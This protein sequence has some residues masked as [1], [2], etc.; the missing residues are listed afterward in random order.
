MSDDAATRR[1]CRGL[2]A[3]RPL[4]ALRRLALANGAQLV[5]LAHHRR[6]QAETFLL[7]ALA[8]RRGRRDWRACRARRAGRRDLGAALAGRSRAT[9][10]DAY[11]RRH[12]LAA[13]R[14]R[15]QRRRRFARNRLRREGLACARGRLSRMRK[16]RLANA[17]DVGA[18]KRAPALARA[19]RARP[20]DDRAVEALDIAALVRAVLRPT[21]QRVARAGCSARRR[22]GARRARRSPDGRAAGLPRRTLAAHTAASCAAIAARL[23]FAATPHGAAEPCAGE[24]TLAIR[25]P[26]SM[27]CRAGAACCSASHVAA[28]RRRRSP[29]STPGAPSARGRRAL[30]GRRRDGRRVR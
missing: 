24:V 18:A 4:A 12:R 26:A 15:Q 8:R 6:D 11:L 14:G 17:A 22:G 25:E 16:R 10:I 1:K 13:C 30:P 20:G 21:L 9:T 3:P 2:G 23:S 27:P 28:R 5:L 29:R 7:Q 19:G